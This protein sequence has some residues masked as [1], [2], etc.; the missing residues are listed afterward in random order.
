MSPKSR[1]VD[2]YL[3][4]RRIAKPRIHISMRTRVQ[5]SS[6]ARMHTAVSAYLASPSSNLPGE[7]QIHSHAL[8][9]KHSSKSYTPRRRIQSPT[10]P[11]QPTSALSTAIRRNS[12][13]STNTANM[14]QTGLKYFEDHPLIKATLRPSTLK[15]YSRDVQCFLESSDIDQLSSYY[16]EDLLTAYIH[17]RYFEDPAAGQRQEMSNLLAVVAL[18]FPHL[19]GKIGRARRSTRG[20]Q[21]K[22]PKIS[23]TTFE[24][25]DVS[26]CIL[27]DCVET[28]RCRRCSC[29][30]MGRIPSSLRST[31]ISMGKCGTP[32]RYPS[33]PIWT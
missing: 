12:D 27:Y 4:A 29:R 26:L 7:P 1:A 31:V 18:I 28:N 23:L 13:H 11:S 25:L 32:W 2:A 9:H 24:G 6:R 20:C 22:T 16:A 14:Q 15:S 19:K 3:S 5:L 17:D 21:I 33:F 30:V 10:T 8:H